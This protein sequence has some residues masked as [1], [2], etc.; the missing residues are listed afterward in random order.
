MPNVQEANL[1]AISVLTGAAAVVSTVDDDGGRRISIF[2]PDRAEICGAFQPVDRPYWLMYV[3]TRIVDG[4]DRSQT[5]LI[6]RRIPLPT[7]R[8]VHQ[9]LELIAG[10]YMRA[11][12]Q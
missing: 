4:L 5:N 12:N 3:T 1:A 7:L 10:L 6:P 8:D 11:A 2:G 9:W